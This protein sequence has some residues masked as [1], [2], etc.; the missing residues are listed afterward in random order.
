[1]RNWL[2]PVL[3]L[4]TF[5]T[6]T[7]AQ[8][9]SIAVEVVGGPKE[10]G[11]TPL[12]VP[13]SLPAE[14][15]KLDEIDVYIDYGGDALPRPTRS[16]L[17]APGLTTEH[18]KP[19]KDGQV[20]RDLQ[21]VLPRVPA[22]Q[23]IYL[24]VR[25]EKVKPQTERFAWMMEKDGMQQAGFAE[26]GAFTPTLRY[27]NR[28]FDDSSKEARDKSY[29]VF[30]HL[31]D[32]SGKRLVTNGAQA[33]GFKGDPK[34]LLFPHHRGIMYAFNRCSYGPDFKKKADT[35]HCTGDAHVTHEKTLSQEAGPVLA[36][37]RNLIHW[38]GEKK[39]VFAIEERELTVYNL[40]GGKLVEF[41][42]RLKTA[43]GP[44]R[45]DGD[46]QHA[47][48]QFRAH[49]DVAAPK[50]AKQTYYLRPDGKGA[51]DET[52]NWDPK[53]KKGPVDLP[54]DVLCFVLDDQ[55]YS[56]AYLNSPTNP[57]QTRFSERNYG[58]FGGYFEYELTEKNPLVVNYRLW[59]Q[60][61]EMTGEQA[62]SL[63]AAFA[64]PPATKVK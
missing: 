4:L 31:F 12:C 52:R 61:G 47:G 19:A 24:D 49:N 17:T 64:S 44:V 29:K 14:L 46:P 27:M 60:D 22:N 57:K 36:R 37:H 16:Q 15:A 3:M 55:R 53:T 48:F 25:L 54:W 35:W 58:R 51:L 10:G 18:V 42:S 38:H 41:A 56:V 11:E 45:L 6:T 26:K 32:P 59:L 23:T 43:G 8:P 1:M 40:A 21:L 20:R 62:A 50:T 34:Q 39:E 33:D 5:A 28:P 30:H 13:L 2:T 63:Y 9:K 7:F